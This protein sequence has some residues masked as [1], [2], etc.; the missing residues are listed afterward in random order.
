M[1]S[2]AGKNEP[3]RQPIALAVRGFFQRYLAEKWIFDVEELTPEI[4]R[5]YASWL[6]AQPTKRGKPRQVTTFN[7]LILA[8]R[9]FLKFLHEQKVLLRNL[10]EHLPLAKEP[11]RLP[12]NILTVEEAEKI[13]NCPNTSTILG[14]R[15]KAILEVLYVTGIRLGEIARLALDDLNLDEG[16]I[17][18]NG[19]KGAKDRVVPIGKVA[20]QFLENYVKVIRPR[21]LGKNKT[22]RL[23]LSVKGQGMSHD[24]IAWTVAKYS[25][26]A[27]IKKRVTPHLWRHSCATHLLQNK[28]NLRH[29]QELLGHRSLAT[30]ERYLHLTITELK[31]AHQQCHPREQG[32]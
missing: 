13:L 3:T 22:E 1:S 15:D 21:I 8:G 11:Q 16:L 24:V 5:E 7:R 10:S 9:V 29:V 12:K 6:Y 27:G 2:V 26:L 19:G 4:L 14:Y 17:R 31:E 20:S 32:V 23:F 25:R 28:A 18:V 30:T